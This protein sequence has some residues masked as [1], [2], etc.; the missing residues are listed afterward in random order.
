ML[1]LKLQIT[2]SS[3]FLTCPFISFYGHMCVPVDNFLLLQVT[4]KY[5]KNCW[6]HSG[7]N[8]NSEQYCPQVSN[9]LTKSAQYNVSEYL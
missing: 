9:N 6:Q 7:E 5:S 4:C 8:E 1:P 2:A 3:T